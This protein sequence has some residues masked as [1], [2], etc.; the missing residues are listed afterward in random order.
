M[1]KAVVAVSFVLCIQELH[2]IDRVRVQEPSLDTSLG[3]GVAMARQGCLAVAERNVVVSDGASQTVAGSLDT[4][5]LGWRLS[6]WPALM[7]PWALGW[8]WFDN[9]LGTI[10]LWRRETL[11]RAKWWQGGFLSWR[12]MLPVNKTCDI[13]LMAQWRSKGCWGWGCRR[14][15]PRCRWG[16]CRAKHWGCRRAKHW[17]CRRACR[18]A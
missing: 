9:R 1:H 3:P 12:P 4:A 2:R 11:A 7:G 6:I 17:G 5:A 15:K 16:C 8:R 14:A 13:L 10:R 18:R